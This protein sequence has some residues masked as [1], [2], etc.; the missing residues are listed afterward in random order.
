M[1]HEYTFESRLYF[2]GELHI[3]SIGAVGEVI[4]HMFFEISYEL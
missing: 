3:A 2:R 1:H 4:F